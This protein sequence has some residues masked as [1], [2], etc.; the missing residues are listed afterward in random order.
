MTNCFTPRLEYI[1]GGTPGKKSKNNNEGESKRVRGEKLEVEGIKF[2]QEP[3]ILK[4]YDKSR[5]LM[6]G[7]SKETGDLTESGILE[8]HMKMAQT[9]F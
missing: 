9:C 2:S 5:K 3:Q 6:G 8:A 1:V 7:V 4:A